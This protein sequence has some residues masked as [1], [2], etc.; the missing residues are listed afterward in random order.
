MADKGQ[1]ERKKMMEKEFPISRFGTY[2][3]EREAKTKLRELRRKEYYAKGK[4]RKE[5]GK[6][7][8]YLEKGAELK[9]KY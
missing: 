6:I 7:K 4:E 1:Y 5:T 3:S 9:G 8:Q 2:I